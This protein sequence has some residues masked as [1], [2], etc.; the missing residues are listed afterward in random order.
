M[1]LIE[2]SGNVAV[3]SA[4]RLYCCAAEII[5]GAVMSGHQLGM[6]LF[7]PCHL[8]GK[9]GRHHMELRYR[10]FSSQVRSLRVPVIRVTVNV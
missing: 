9:S 3:V 7:E 1:W 10:F 4:E 6:T 5:D 2:V 8:P